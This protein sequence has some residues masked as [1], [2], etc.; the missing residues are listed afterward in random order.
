MKKRPI[1]Y[2]ISANEFGGS[3]NVHT[4]LANAVIFWLV[5]GGICGIV[6]ALCLVG[7]LMLHYVIP[8]LK[9]DDPLVI[10][11]AEVFVALTIHSLSYGNWI[12]VDFLFI[13]GLLLAVNRY[14]I[15]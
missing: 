12:S 4:N 5:S 11:V 14:K 7:Y 9:S 8:A 15:E 6:A 13:T 1:G 2:G 10:A 3:N